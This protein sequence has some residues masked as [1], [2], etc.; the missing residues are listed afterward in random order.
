VNRDCEAIIRIQW[1]V[2]VGRWGLRS[3]HH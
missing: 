2:L 1:I 3:N